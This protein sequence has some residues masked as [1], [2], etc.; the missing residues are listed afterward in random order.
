[1]F[2][3]HE[4]LFR[5]VSNQH[6]LTGA[7]ILWFMVSHSHDASLLSTGMKRIVGPRGPSTACSCSRT[8]GGSVPFMGLGPRVRSSL[9]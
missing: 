4:A 2:N 7:C 1:M 6:P 8:E 5:I 3:S 9:I